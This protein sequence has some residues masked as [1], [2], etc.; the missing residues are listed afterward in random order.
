ME[1][2]AL[3]KYFTSGS[4]G[5][6]L[7]GIGC[8]VVAILWLVLRSSLNI[9]SDRI[10]FLE[11]IG[12]L[13]GPIMIVTS[14]KTIRK[15]RK[16][17]SILRRNNAIGYVYNSFSKTN[18]NLSYADNSVIISDYYLFLKE[19][20]MVVTYPEI[21]RVY[22]KYTRNNKNEVTSSQLL[23]ST[24]SKEDITVFSSIKNQDELMHFLGAIR[25]KN[26]YVQIE[27]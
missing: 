8:S 21:T 3:K 17:M 14:L 2:K 7:F 20:V 6:S 1:E 12:L 9:L 4:M 24:T 18:E 15:A 25:Q 23:C 10:Y 22:M 5:S 27:F 11:V 13:M 26:P 16:L 19:P